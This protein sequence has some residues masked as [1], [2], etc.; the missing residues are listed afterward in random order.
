MG[1][2]EGASHGSAAFWQPPALSLQSQS[3]ST[4]GPS[5]LL[6]F[7]PTAPHPQAVV[8]SR[9]L[10][11]PQLHPPRAGTSVVP[12]ARWRSRGAP[13]GCPCW[14][15]P[16]AA[17]RQAAHPRGV[18]SRGGPFFTTPWRSRFQTSPAPPSI[19]QSLLG[20]RPPAVGGRQMAAKRPNSF[21]RKPLA[22]SQSCQLQATARGLPS[23]TR[24]TG[25]RR[26]R[27]RRSP[28]S[29]PANARQQP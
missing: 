24:S 4:S 16:A 27:M 14:G 13:A 8:C 21:P 11:P 19:V 28:Y 26:L 9:R 17:R 15:I 23:L 5:Q 6:T 10:Q 22:V 3:R 25:F 29:I 20:A 18:V 1:C 12:A 2:R 7:Q